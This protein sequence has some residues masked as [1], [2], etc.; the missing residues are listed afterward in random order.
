MC[1]NINASLS[2]QKVIG[3]ARLTWSGPMWHNDRPEDS[4]ANTLVARTRTRAR[5]PDWAS[6]DRTAR[7][8]HLQCNGCTTANQ[9]QTNGKEGAS[10]GE[11]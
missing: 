11:F 7:L 6:N 9:I 8:L 4:W 2:K 1:T 5:S 3:R 10:A